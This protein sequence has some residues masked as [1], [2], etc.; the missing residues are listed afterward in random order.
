MNALFIIIDSEPVSLGFQLLLVA[1]MAVTALVCWLILRPL[2][3]KFR[4]WLSAPHGVRTNLISAGILIVW[5]AGLWILIVTKHSYDNTLAM[6]AASV[7]LC[8][9][10]FSLVNTFRKRA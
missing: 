2:M 8:V 9:G 7:L 4:R 6:V 3:P 1:V 5:G 10:I